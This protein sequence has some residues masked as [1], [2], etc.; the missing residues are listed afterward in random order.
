ME[1]HKRKDNCCTYLKRAFEK[2]GIENFKFRIICI[3]FDDDLNKYEIEY[4]KKYDTIV[5]NGY[6]LS[7]GGSFGFSGCKHSE[8]TKAILSIQI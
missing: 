8:E 7:E 2:Y 5:P 3:C 1:S 6:N 4:I